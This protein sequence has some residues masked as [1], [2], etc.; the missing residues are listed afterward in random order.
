V[1]HP[2]L[3]WNIGSACRAAATAAAT[4][5]GIAALTGA[6]TSSSATLVGWA[7]LPANTFADG[8]TTGQFAGAGQFGNSLPIVERQ[9][10]QGF[11][12][13]LAGPSPGSYYVLTD[14]GFGS[15]SNSADALLRVYAI[16]PDFRTTSGGSGAVAAANFR[17]G[18]AMERFS[19]ESFITLRD[20]ERR[21]SFGLVADRRTYTSS[22]GSPPV[23]PAIATNRW[24][25]G[26]DL[27]VESFQVDSTGAWWFGDEFGPFLVKAS[28]SGVIERAEI[29]LEAVVAPEHPK[30]GASSTIASSRGFEGLASDPSR[31]RLYAM[32]EGTVRG[33][34]PSTLR[35]YEFDTTTEQFTGRVWRYRLDSAGTNI[36]EL[37]AIDDHTF[38]VLERNGVS[39]IPGAAAPFKKIFK[40][41]LSVAAEDGTVLKAEVADLM[42][43]ADPDDLN[44]DGEKTFTFPFVTIESVL[45]IDPTTLLVVNDNNYPGGGGR[46]A[47]SD[48]TEVILIRL[49]RPLDR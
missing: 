41:D 22:P 49:S 39:G 4:L 34:A 18:L 21:L 32:V 10:V 3:L 27:D 46:G 31:R 38:L 44:R 26:A 6:Q 37:A 36:G 7:M 28:A 12:A 42:N 1:G 48:N 29:G 16:R 30:A 8:P 35:I 17:T 13:V 47:A 20:P 43:V 15:R 11:S 5:L 9:V 33:D 25:T 23:A 40:V 45:V 14:N 24:L 19:T 2:P